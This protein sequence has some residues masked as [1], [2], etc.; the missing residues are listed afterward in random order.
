MYD[1]VCYFFFLLIP[2]IFFFLFDLHE[3]LALFHPFV[4][5]KHIL[6]ADLLSSLAVV[7][8]FPERTQYTKRKEK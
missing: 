1:E 8:V 2:P 6:L 5:F 3:D 7:F 4:L